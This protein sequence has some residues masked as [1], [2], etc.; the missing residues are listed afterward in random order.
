MKNLTNSHFLAVGLARN[1][2]ATIKND[3]LYVQNA[4]GNTPDNHWLVIESDSDDN[5]LEVLEELKAI[6]P[7][8]DYISLGTLRD[9]HPLRTDRIAICRNRYLEE[10]ETNPN[11]A[12]LTHLLV[13]DLDGVNDCI[14]DN[15]IASCFVRD[16]WAA[17]T[18]NQ[19]GPYYDV[20]ALRHEIWSPNDCWDVQRFLGMRG[21]NEE[22]STACA[23]YS[24]MISISESED[25]IEVDS[26]FGGLGI[27]QVAAIH[28]LRYQGLNQRGEEVSEHVSF[29]RQIRDS[30]GKIFINP[31]LING[32]LNEHSKGFIEYQKKRQQSN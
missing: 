4:L 27:Y 8:F 25:W 7:N 32:T 18:A 23:V 31:R 6:V 14:T 1:C 9:K 16:D 11:Y 13:A 12:N 30:G 17:C 19:W 26:A 28:G 5:T 20:Y 21:M 24:R 15:A 10:L 29:H 22:E 2:A 3:V